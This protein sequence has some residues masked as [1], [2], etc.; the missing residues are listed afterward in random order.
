MP[1]MEEERA[2]MGCSKITSTTNMRLLLKL[3][4]MSVQQQS[5]KKLLKNLTRI[6]MDLVMLL[7]RAKIDLNA[8]LS[9]F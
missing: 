6:R 3:S 2:L 7:K 1:E 8:L 5:S 4:M 9:T